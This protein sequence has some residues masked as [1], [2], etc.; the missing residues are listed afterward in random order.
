MNMT[1]QLQALAQKDKKNTLVKVIGTILDLKRKEIAE[2]DMNEVNEDLK[3]ILT[4]KQ[5]KGDA[6]SRLILIFCGNSIQFVKILNEQFKLKSKDS[7]CTFIDNK[8]GSKS[9]AGHFCKIRILYALDPTEY[10]AQKIKKLGRGQNFKKNQKKIAEIFV[11]RM[12][13]DLDRIQRVWKNNKLC[14]GGKDLKQWINAKT[15]GSKSGLFLIKM[16]E[17]CPRYNTITNRNSIKGNKIEKM[18]M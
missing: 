7:L 6:K 1:K 16:L 3:F 5:F 2:V 13:V 9:T 15:N 8:L 17:N 14:D 11:Q 18:M 10:Y 4:S 12:E